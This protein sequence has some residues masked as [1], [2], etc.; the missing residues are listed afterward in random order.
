MIFEILRTDFKPVNDFLVNA[1][2][3]IL[4]KISKFLSNKIPVKHH[5]YAN[6]KYQ[7]RKL[8][9]PVHGL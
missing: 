1:K 3:G 6:Q 7:H 4:V 2:T 8:V 9:H 5:G